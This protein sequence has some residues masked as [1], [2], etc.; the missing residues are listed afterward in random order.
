MMPSDWEW[1]AGLVD[2][3]AYASSHRSRDEAVAA[4]QRL[5]EPGEQ[6]RIIEAR[7]STAAKYD[8]GYY[9][10]VPFTHTRHHEIITN[11]PRGQ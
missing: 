8:T 6:F 2:D 7:S 5:A 1:W 4:G 3:E 10:F 9:D 11:G